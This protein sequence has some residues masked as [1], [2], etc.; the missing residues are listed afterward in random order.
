MLKIKY[1][2][3]MGIKII[4]GSVLAIL[5]VLKI[6]VGALRIHFYFSYFTGEYKLP[7]HADQMDQ[8]LTMKL[9]LHVVDLLQQ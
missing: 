5:Q 6:M 2:T 9:F 3:G 4:T 1:R 8:N 7:C